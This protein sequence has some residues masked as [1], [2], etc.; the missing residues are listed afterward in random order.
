[1][2]ENCVSRTKTSGKNWAVVWR[3][4]WSELYFSLFVD[5]WRYR[6]LHS[7][8]TS[9]WGTSCCRRR[10]N[11]SCCHRKTN[12]NFGRSV[13]CIDSFPYY[14]GHNYTLKLEWASTSNFTIY[15]VIML[16]CG[17]FVLSNYFISV[18]DSQRNC[19]FVVRQFVYLVCSINHGMNYCVIGF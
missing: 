17:N 8:H 14:H 13:L 4:L 12:N 1:M 15:L 19:C 6:H 5:R 3:S 10:G 16:V 9:T 7:T 11:F 2:F 18:Q